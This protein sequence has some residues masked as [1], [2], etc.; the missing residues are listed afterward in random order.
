MDKKQRS[1]RVD[2]VVL[3][4][5]EWG[6]ADRLLTL[7]TRQLGKVKAIAKGVRK[8]RSRKAGHLEPFTRSSLQLAR[9]RDL[10]II[11]QAEAT[12]TYSTL[13]ENLEY[14]GYGSYVI[15]VLTRFTYEEGENLALFRLLV[16]TL[17]RLERGD[18]P[19]IVI[20]Y[21]EIR[22][23]DLVGFRPQLFVCT[24]CEDEIQPKNQ[25]FSAFLGGVL[26][27][28]CGHRTN[29]GRP[30]SIEALKYLRHFQRSS[31]QEATRAQ[32]D[33]VVNAEIEGLMNYYLT[34][35]LERGLNT[36][37]FINRMK[38]ER[39]TKNTVNQ[40]EESLE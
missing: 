15:E 19:V 34:H 39:A 30:I 24:Q 26:C 23:L 17:Q 6:E 11:T 27:P 25:F 38:Q 21:Y 8:L 33:P 2:A 12:H 31:Y 36:P 16:D 22:L 9:G 1:F 5:V 20:H 29:E 7:F 4:H 32:I 40:I 13:R 35:I 37:A 28:K 18:D 14:L 3:H 10:F